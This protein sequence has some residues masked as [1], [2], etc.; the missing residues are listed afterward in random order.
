VAAKGVEL[1][2]LQEQHDA[3]VTEIER[4]EAQLSKASNTLW[5]KVCRLGGSA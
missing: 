5:A 3:R 1:G 4:L 2:A